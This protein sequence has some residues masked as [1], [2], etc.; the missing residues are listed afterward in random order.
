MGE[1]SNSTDGGA[2]ESRGTTDDA[3]SDEEEMMGIEAMI[4]LKLVCKHG[5][6]CYLKTV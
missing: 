2:R 5:E 4:V 3:G 6:Y 1:T